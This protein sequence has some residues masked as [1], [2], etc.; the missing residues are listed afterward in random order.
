LLELVP[1]L[2]VGKPPDFK[3]TKRIQA[4]EMREVNRAPPEWSA[5]PPLFRPS[6]PEE[7]VQLPGEDEA[8]ASAL[9]ALTPNL[10]DIEAGR[11]EGED[12]AVMDAAPVPER[13]EWEPRQ[14]ILAIE[15]ELFAEDISALPRHRIPNLPRVAAAPDVTLPIDVS[16]D[17]ARL[18]AL[19][20][21]M[22]VAAGGDMDRARAM[23][24]TSLRTTGVLPGTGPL[25]EP[26][27]LSGEADEDVT[28]IRPVE[29]VLKLD[30]YTYEADYEDAVYFK[31]QIQ[32]LRDDALPV[33]P[34]DVLLIQDCSESMTERKL[35]RCKTGLHAWLD[36]LGPEDR[37]DL[38]GFRDEAYRCFGFWT[39]VTPA[40]RARAN[41]FINN[42]SSRGRTDVYA[43]LEPLLELDA[44]PQRPVVAVL[45]TD[46]RP[47]MGL[48]D[49]SD[50][51]ETFSQRNEG[52][53]SVFAFGGGRRVNRYLLDLLS[54]KNRGDSL[55]V[56]AD[57]D[58]PTGL[59]DWA[60]QLSRPVLTELDFRFAGLDESEIYPRTLT[61][62]YLDRPL[63]IYGRT[64]G[65]LQ[66]VAF[67]VLGRSGPVPHDMVFRLSWD[68]AHAAGEQLRTA[69][70][71]HKAYHLIGEHIRTRDDT[72]MDQIRAVEARYGL[73]VPYGGDYPTRY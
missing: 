15:N 30:L 37:F 13:P 65:A 16:P 6:N 62:L 10:P 68:E 18:A 19:A 27:R 72:V 23:R 36:R 1:P 64:V 50:I 54:Y 2:P 21:T 20:H 63:E 69:W 58:I 60:G 51:I 48:V 44:T 5:R 52:R 22:P 67:Q 3:T 70:A 49:S 38:M 33:L 4:V 66:K 25:D 29:T 11:F 61:H 55:V 73:A 40:T 26:F 31:I 34:K 35:K 59:D 53:V 7:F 42:M 14:D 47:T 57:A 32:R 45:V 71:W 12:A 41:W 39:N 24:G 17:L 43:S 56:Q 9:D 46:G 8:F 28:D